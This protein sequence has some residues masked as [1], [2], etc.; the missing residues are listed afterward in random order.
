MRIN[1]T[2]ATSVGIAML[3]FTFLACEEKEKKQTTAEADLVAT[4]QA[5]AP[6]QEQAK[7]SFF[8]DPRDGKKYRTVKIGNQTWMAEN[9]NYASPNSACHRK[10]P[11]NCKKYGALYFWKEA[12]KVCPESWHLPTDSEWYTLINF[13][14]GKSNAGTK[15]KARTGWKSQQNNRGE[16]VSSNGTDNY[17]FAALPGGIQ[18]AHYG[19]VDDI[20]CFWSGLR[21]DGNMQCFTISSD[22]DIGA[23]RSS[24][25]TVGFYSIRC[26][27]YDEAQLA[28]IKAEEQA[29][30]DAEA[31]AEAD[32]KAKAEAKI[33]ELMK[34]WTENLGEKT[35]D[36]AVKLCSSKGGRLP[37]NEEWE[38]VAEAVG[39]EDNTK[40]LLDKFFP[41]PN[42][43]MG[44]WWSATKAESY[45]PNDPESYYWQKDNYFSEKKS[46]KNRAAINVRCI[47]Q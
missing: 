16:T 25:N 42:G 27:T 23:E 9:L 2:V 26:V 30:K 47:K 12:E 21:S 4:E 34:N 41:V 7:G 22:A 46:A 31:K 29:E 24:L 8:T 11:E 40:E 28:A 14:G 20:A 37:T 43:G 33:K 18:S 10:D 13:A 15:L 17:G 39:N 19:M 38:A 45:N 44:D 5:E 1:R 32:K 3:A 35:W 6:A 36:E